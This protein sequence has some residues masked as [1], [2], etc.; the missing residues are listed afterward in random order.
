MNIELI[1]PHLNY[2][3]QHHKRGKTIQREVSLTC[4]KVIY[5]STGWFKIIEVPSFD[6]EEDSQGNQEYIDN[7]CVR[8]IYM[9][10]HTW[11]CR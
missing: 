9:F 6:Q 2:T 11:L 10:D 4:M 5:K 7:S 8:V 1:G 3:R